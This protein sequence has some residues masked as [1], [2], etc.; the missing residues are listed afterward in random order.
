[1][2]SHAL[3]LILALIFA[4]AFSASAEDSGSIPGANSPQLWNTNGFL[5]INLT[6]D[7]IQNPIA[8][9]NRSSISRL[10]LGDNLS[11]N[12]VQLSPGTEIKMHYHKGIEEL[13]LVVGGRGIINATGMNY[14]IESGDL[15]HLPVDMPSAVYALGDE[16]LDLISIYAPPS[17]GTRTYV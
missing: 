15:I 1:M 8:E 12:H 14:T 3:A 6:D 16:N 7:T 4:Q 9:G 5:L 11:A 17:D 2:R 10:V 13:I